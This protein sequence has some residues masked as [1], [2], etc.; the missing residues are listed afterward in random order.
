MNT[1]VKV[2][3]GTVLVVLFTGCALLQPRFRKSLDPQ[4]GTVVL[5]GLS[6]KAFIRRDSMGVPFIEASN[7]DD[8]FLATGYAHASDRLWQMVTMK[9][10]IQGRLSEISGKDT[11]PIDLFMRTLNVK[12]HVAE[13]MSELDPRS[14]RIL[15]N[16]AEGVN[17]YI[18]SHQ[19]LPAEF[20]LARYRPEPWKDEDSL[21]IFAMLNLFLSFNFLEELDYLVV[22]QAIGYRKAAWLV[23]VYPD[24]PLPF[25]EAEKLASIPGQ[26]L[27]RLL[28]RWKD[29]RGGLK[30]FIPLNVPASNNWALAPVKTRSRKSLLANDTHLVLAMPCQWLAVH[31]KCPGY[32]AAGV[33]VPGIPII[34]LGYNGKVAWGATMVTADSQDIFIE[35]LKE[36]D[37]KTWYLYRNRWIPVEERTETI[38]IKGKKPYILPVRKT[39]HGVLLNSALEKMPYPAELPVQPVPMK[40]PYGLALRW[41]MEG[42][43][44]SLR[45]FY[46]LSRSRSVTE[47]GRAMKD[48][49]SIYL[50]MVY[51]DALTIA[52]QVT[53]AV[54]VRKKGRGLLPSPGW[55]GHYDWTGFL[56]CEKLPRRI[57]PPA[58]YLATA[59]N[60]T[61][62]KDFP[63]NLS[64]T[65]YHPDRADRLREALGPMKN[66]TLEDMEKL[67]ADRISPMALKARHVIFSGAL[68]ADIRKTIDSW[69]EGKRKRRALEALSF[70][71]PS[72]FNGEMKESSAPAAVMGCFFHAFVHRTF[73][74]ELG[75]EKSTRWHSFIE[76]NAIS[77]SAPEDHLLQRDD[78]PFWDNITTGQK[79][80]KAHIIAESLA[81]AVELCEKK[82]GRDRRR[83]QWGK[84]HTYHWKHDISKATSLFNNYLNRGPFPAGGDVHTINVAGFMW[85]RNFDVWMIPAMRML[86]DFGRD[87]PL[88]LVL[89]M[90]QSG[91]PS[92]PHYDDMLPLYLE[93]KN[94]SMP[95][96]AE[97]IRRHYTRE[98]RL[99]PGSRADN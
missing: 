54:P 95:F 66:A 32:E 36:A 55:D 37:G 73:L 90:G 69:K 27:L 57:N 26:E 58:G 47:A 41:A 24:E 56:P 64:A 91:N 30:K 4:E 83:W 81:G 68:A 51:A 43:G 99:L 11:L 65:W 72:R 98:L 19:D 75:P 20:I 86:V 42:I 22:A 70:L 29:I 33:A 93:V 18:R 60:R 85:G 52:W 59:N 21:Y 14:R 97:G 49:K 44:V 2:I 50:N 28:A 79:E 6:G 35:K 78:S 17:A 61:V 34:T 80:T 23:P 63:Y 92:S 12:S 45:G 87:E 5:K 31:L 89:S 53:G 48:I 39:L 88:Y 84:I 74:D 7:E 67:Q 76:L 13:A 71:D 8:L 16:Y 9:M 62:G 46:N 82:M 10:T 3:A 1:P 40:S 15:K 25:D 38:E 94:R 96:S 77:Y